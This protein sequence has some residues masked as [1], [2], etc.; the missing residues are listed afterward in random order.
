M[1]VEISFLLYNIVIHPN[2]FDSPD[3]FPSV[4][5]FS[6]YGSLAILLFRRRETSIVR[7]FK[8]DKMK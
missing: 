6:Y 7:V 1:L 8:R 3:L 5:R 2:F 4:F